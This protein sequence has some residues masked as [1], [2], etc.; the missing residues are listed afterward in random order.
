[1]D[2]IPDLAAQLLADTEFVS[3]MCR[4]SERLLTEK[5]IRRKYNLT[6]DAWERLGEDDALIGRPDEA[7]ASVGKIFATY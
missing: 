1:M 7:A 4:Y 6:D 2:S 3:D 5:F